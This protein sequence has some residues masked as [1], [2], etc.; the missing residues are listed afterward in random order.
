[1]ELIGHA[2]LPTALQQTILAIATVGVIGLD[3]VDSLQ[4]APTEN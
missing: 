2:E 1:M 4:H 3:A